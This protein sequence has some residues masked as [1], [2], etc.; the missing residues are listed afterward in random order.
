MSAAPRTIKPYVP[1]PSFAE[2]RPKS[3]NF[4]IFD[5]MAAQMQE[6]KA[7]A[8]AEDMKRVIDIATRWA[9]ADTGA[10][11][12]LYE[13]DRGFTFSV[14]VSAAAWDQIHLI[15]GD[16]TARAMNDAMKAYDS[17][18]DAATR[19]RPVTE[20]WIRELH[21]TICASQNAYTVLTEVGPRERELVKGK[22]KIEPNSPLNLKSNEVHSYAPVLDTGPEMARFVD[23]LRAEEFLEAHPILQ[24]AYAHYAFVCIHPFP[25]GNGRVSRALA[26]V[27]LYRNPGMPLVIFADQKNSYIDALEAADA[28]D[29]GDFVRFISERAIDTIGLIRV[30]FAGSSKPPIEVQLQSIQ[31]MLTGRGGL[32]HTQVDAI[33][34]RLGEVIQSA[35]SRQL[36]M[37][38]L[39]APLSV[40]FSQFGSTPTP[41]GY[42]PVPSAY[43]SPLA[44]GISSAPPAEGQ[45]LR[46]YAVFVA[47]PSNDG[48]DYL[49]SSGGRS[50]LEVFLRELNPVV[51]EALVYRA[52]GVARNELREML[53]VV[54]DQARE[55]LRNRGYAQ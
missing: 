26:S 29:A 13:V 49:V 41:N 17:V 14:A 1:F 4:T 23:E 42:R 19:A 21:A 9:A 24:A 22:Y 12:G 45:E 33:A 18:L 30:E 38:P 43:A 48:P 27:Y 53:S 5:L 37:N 46:V 3:S 10:I 39:N 35:F 50:L 16:D 47:L 7:S 31:Q 20:T 51:S 11:E 6:M 25:D 40:N 32:E 36:Q 2:W 52:E 28:G 54:T 44:V 8:S 55:S 34:G 15:K